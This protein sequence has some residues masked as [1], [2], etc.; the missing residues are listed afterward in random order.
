MYSVIDK[1]KLFNNKGN[2]T[3]KTLVLY[4]PPPEKTRIQYLTS[5]STSND[6]ETGQSEFLES[7]IGKKKNEPL[8]NHMAYQFEKE[9]F[10]SVILCLADL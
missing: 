9:L 6:I 2:Y 4:P 7:I 1:F 8:L 3:T 5:I 10:I